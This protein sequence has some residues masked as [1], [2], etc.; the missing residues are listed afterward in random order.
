M[1]DVRKDE[2]GNPIHCD[3]CEWTGGEDDV[4]YIADGME[5]LGGTGGGICLLPAGECPECGALAYY[6]DQVPAWEVAKASPK[7]LAALVTLHQYW[8]DAIVGTPDVA[9]DYASDGYRIMENARAAI[10]KAEGPKAVEPKP[11]PKAETPDDTQPSDDECRATAERQYADGSNDDVEIDGDAVVSRGD[12][13]AFVAA[14]VHIR[15][16]EVAGFEDYDSDD[17]EGGA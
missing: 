5:R 1:E 11:E 3:N 15:F 9:T 4:D 16:S 10:A 6:D 14:W 2:N 12:D 17:D 8:A 13:G 7:L